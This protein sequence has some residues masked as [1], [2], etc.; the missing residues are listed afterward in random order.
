MALDGLAGAV[1]ESSPALVLWIRESQGADQLSH[2]PGL[3]LS[4]SCR[5]S[6]TQDN[7]RIT[8]SPNEDLIL[9]VSQKPEVWNQTTDSLQ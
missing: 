8:R 1:L 7:S 5:I 4:W 6:M 3:D 9:M 2:Y